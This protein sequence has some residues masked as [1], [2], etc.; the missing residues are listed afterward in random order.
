MTFHP[1]IYDGTMKERH[2]KCF[3]LQL[4]LI[5]S[6]FR[7]INLYLCSS[8]LCNVTLYLWNGVGKSK[9]ERSK[10]KEMKDDTKI[11]NTQNILKNMISDFV[12]Y[13]SQLQSV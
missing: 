9:N 5:T 10:L 12:S 11:P 1:K 2:Y 3:D 8:Y 13:M 6:K 7:L 4:I